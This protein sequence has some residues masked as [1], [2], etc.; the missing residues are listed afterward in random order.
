VNQQSPHPVFWRL[1]GGVSRLRLEYWGARV[2]VELDT[3][4]GAKFPLSGHWFEFKQCPLRPVGDLR[5]TL[6]VDHFRCWVLG[7]LRFSRFGV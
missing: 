7:E 6:Y 2:L 5:W 4:A 1:L 3:V